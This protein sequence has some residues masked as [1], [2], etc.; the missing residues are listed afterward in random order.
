MSKKKSF[1]EKEFIPGE[2]AIKMVEM[3]MRDLECCIYL[4][5]KAAAVFERIDSNFESSSTLGKMPPNSTACY[6]EI[7]C[8]RKLIDVA[9]FTV[10]SYFKQLPQPLNFKNYHLDQ[11]A[12]I[13]TEART[14]TSEDY[15]WITGLR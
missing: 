4:V 15:N 9:N 6:R 14:T 10:L 3:T 12:A 5:E 13:N 1:L 11:I 2:N 8:E 7:I